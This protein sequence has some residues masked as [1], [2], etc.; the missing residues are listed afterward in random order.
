MVGAAPEMVVEE[1]PHL[2]RIEPSLAAKGVFRAQVAEQGEEVAGEPGIER[3]MNTALR[4]RRMRGGEESVPQ[5]KKGR[6]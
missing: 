4:R 5:A 3:K 1:S 2:S 6:D